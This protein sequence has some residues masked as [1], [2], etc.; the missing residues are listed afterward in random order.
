MTT[1]KI[2]IAFGGIS[3]EHEV[4]V[5]TAI[6][7][8]AALEKTNAVIIPLYIAKNGKWYTGA[9]LKD[10][11]KYNDVP[12]LLASSTPCTFKQDDLGRVSLIESES[13]GFFRK[14]IVYT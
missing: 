10:L 2:L 5:L 8:M 9:A 3:P 12:S 1:K 13:R 6:Q 11:D 14:P 4:S 7:A